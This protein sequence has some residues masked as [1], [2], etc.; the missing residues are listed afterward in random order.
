MVKTL[1]HGH[2]HG[3]CVVSDQCKIVYV[4]IPKN[5]SCLLRDFMTKNLNGYEE[6]YF[7]LTQ[8]QQK[9]HDVLHCTQSQGSFFV[10]IEHNFT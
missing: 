7:K 2:I 9:V 5:A 1:G 10:S 3:Q 4:F 6:N 8:Q